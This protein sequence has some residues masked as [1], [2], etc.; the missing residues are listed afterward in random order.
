MPSWARRPGVADVRGGPP[1][2]SGLQSA[3]G[4]RPRVPTT[5]NP[6]FPDEL[7]SGFLDDEL[8][9]SERAQV[10]RHLASHPADRQWIEELRTLRAELQRLPPVTVSPEFTQRVVQ[11]ALTAERR[12][13]TATEP[14]APAPGKRRW[15][16]IAIGMLGV[17]ATFVLGVWLGSR[18]AERPQPPRAATAPLADALRSGG[19]RSAERPPQSPLPEDP[20]RRVLAAAG[21]E[22]VLVL[23][24]RVGPR[25]LPPAEVDAALSAAGLPLR[26][27][28][29]LA[30]GASRLVPAW[31]RLVQERL[32]ASSAPSADS[33]EQLA[34]P[35]DALWIEAPPGTVESFLR[36]LGGTASD[37]LVLEARLAVSS[38]STVGDAE[39]EGEPGQPRGKA[40]GNALPEG[41]WV[42]RLPPSLFPLPRE[43]G[44][45]SQVLPAAREAGTV[46]RVLLLIERSR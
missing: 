38:S 20:I 37:T 35:G 5:M 41:P 7:L 36:R 45:L 27:A 4:A 28:S 17:A 1:G 21:G 29:D 32:A 46:C 13:R 31:R 16:A 15:V 42:Q 3:P 10:E 26:S 30:S 9:P 43:A 25:P 24:L 12:R 18:F 19:L 44:R 22:Q 33:A 8:S 6:E 14:A 2:W 23:R 11:A 39:A 34:T 40:A